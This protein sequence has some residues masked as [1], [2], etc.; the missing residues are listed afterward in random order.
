MSNVFALLATAEADHGNELPEG[1]RRRMI[2]LVPGRSE[3]EAATEAMLAM[4][5]KKWRNA[6]VEQIEPVSADIAAH[7]DPVL[8]EAAAR[9]FAGN[10]SLIVYEPS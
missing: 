6:R 9:A 2:V 10:R 4:A 1:E 7:T 8:R 3:D 5:D